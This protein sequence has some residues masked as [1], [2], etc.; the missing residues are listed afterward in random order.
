MAQSQRL[1]YLPAM[2]ATCMLFQTIYLI[3]VVLWMLF[4]ELKGHIIL[5]NI[6]PEFT[7]LDIPSFIYGMVASAMYGWIVAAIFVFF[8]NLWPR[9]AG[10]IFGTKPL[11]Q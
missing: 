10:A 5:M 6:F 7:L 1:D 3:C 4:P 11:R 8:Y 2:F 9:F